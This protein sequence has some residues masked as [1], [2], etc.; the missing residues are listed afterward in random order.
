MKT[1]RTADMDVTMSFKGK[2]SSKQYAFTDFSDRIKIESKTAKI[3]KDRVKQKL[4]NKR[5]MDTAT[6][7]FDKLE[8]LGKSMRKVQLVMRPGLDEPFK[9]KCNMTHIE[10]NLYPNLRGNEVINIEGTL[11]ISQVKNQYP[12]AL[13]VYWS[14]DMEEFTNAYHNADNVN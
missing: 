7:G 9:G 11:S 4:I 3:L 2:G 13:A 12:N 8:M 10:V 14:K 6:K 5:A 1:V